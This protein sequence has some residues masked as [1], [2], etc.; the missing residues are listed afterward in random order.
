MTSDNNTPDD[1]E[2]VADLTRVAVQEYD[3]VGVRDF[4]R[5]PPGFGNVLTDAELGKKRNWDSN[6]GGFIPT[7]CVEFIKDQPTFAVGV[8]KAAEIAILAYKRYAG[9]GVTARQIVGVIKAIAGSFG[10]GAIAESRVESFLRARGEE[11]HPVQ[12]GDENSGVDI[13][14]DVRKY[15]VKL[16]A[17]YRSDWA[18]K[19]ADM[20]VWVKPDGTIHSP[21]GPD[22][23][24]DVTRLN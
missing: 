18:N 19:S 23:Y 17:D 20:V 4:E 9:C 22:G 10:V 15:Q 5:G 14:T 12:E 13:R 1:I 8:A 2:G 21:Y 6:N 7:N 3:G 24:K 16:S 11:V